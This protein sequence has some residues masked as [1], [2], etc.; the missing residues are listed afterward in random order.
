MHQQIAGVAEDKLVSCTRG[1]IYDVCVDL[2]EG[3]PTWGKYIGA[4]LSEENGTMLYVPKGCA[5]GYLILREDS[6]VLYFV[7]EFYQLGNEMG[8]WYDEPV[9]AIQWPLQASYIL[10]DK[11]RNWPF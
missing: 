4:C 5:H 7:T 2:R 1:K 8:Y 3:S 6:Q 10:S 9:F 11:E